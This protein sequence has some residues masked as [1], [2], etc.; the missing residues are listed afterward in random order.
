MGPT[1]SSIKDVRRTVRYK[2]LSPNP[3]FLGIKVSTNQ[4]ALQIP[5]VICYF[6]LFTLLRSKISTP[7]ILNFLD[8]D[9]SVVMPSKIHLSDDRRDNALQ[10][11]PDMLTATNPLCTRCSMFQLSKMTKFQ[12]RKGAR[13]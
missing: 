2:F 4:F 11:K 3:S 1:S 13:E 7:D 9:V 10:G 6:H 5:M 8:L 12:S